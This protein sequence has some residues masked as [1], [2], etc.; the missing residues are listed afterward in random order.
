MQ[1]KKK[2]KISILMI[3]LFTLLA[4]YALS[5][6]FSLG[7]GFL[8]S[9]KSRTD[10]LRNKLGFPDPE[11]S[12][13]QLKFGNYGLVLQYVN[14]K[15]GGQAYTTAFGE[16]VPDVEYIGI[17]GMLLNTVLYTVVN[18]CLNAFIPAICAYVCVEYKFK[19]GGILYAVNLFAMT[20]PIVGSTPSTITLLRNLGIFDTWIGS[21]V[22][23]LTFT[24]TYFFVFWA[25]YQGFSGAY[26]EAAEIDGASQWQV[27]VNI[28]LPL[29]MKTITTVALLNFVILWNDYN[30][31][32]LYM[33]THPTLAYGVWYFA[34]SGHVGNAQGLKP[35]I[36]A[37]LGAIPVQLTACMTLALPLLVIFVIFKEKLM[38]NISAGGV[39]E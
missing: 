16:V 1:T 11:Y 14:V 8:T 13:E 34:R 38:G 12:S 7:F 25:F 3:I 19:I 35:I 39:K 2:R 6:F 29:S 20:M 26:S 17:G 15:V 10:F 23:R 28:I 18:A 30:T 33:P 36:K 24:G 22:L 9:L 21:W 4:L 27:L 32:V 5:I 37:Q 31:T